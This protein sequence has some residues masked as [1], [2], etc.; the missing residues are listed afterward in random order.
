TTGRDLL[1]SLDMQAQ[2]LL[3]RVLADH[4]GAGVIVDPATGD[5]LAM[6]SSPGFDPNR[7]TP[8]LPVD[9][10][11]RISG[12]ERRPLMN[13]AISATYS[14]G[15]T[16]KPVVA[17]AALASGRAG[18]HT[19]FS[20]PG[21][22]NLGRARFAC[23]YPS[24]HGTVDLRT[25]IEKSCNVYFFQLALQCGL[26]PIREAAA[27]LGLG[28]ATGIELEAEY[29][30]LLPSDA[31]KRRTFNDAWRDGD[32]CNLAIGQGFLAVTPLQMALLTAALAN[33]GTLHAPRLVLGSRAPGEESFE[34]LPPSAAVPVN[35][36]PSAIR[37]VRGAMRDVVMS[38]GG[39][40]RLAQIPNV[41][42]AG[43]TGTAEYGKKGEGLKLGWMIAFAPYDAPRYAV[44]L[45]L[46]EA[47]TGGRTTAPV[48]KEILRGLFEQV[49]P[50][51]G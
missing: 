31:W 43:K 6:T 32:T 33:G 51:R 17:L 50:A 4:V 34:R 10:W 41:V 18:V 11:R 1:L 30:G 5:V 15:S 23:W 48:M 27:A 13:R 14:P 3:D 36:P 47:D 49:P 25:A 19:S 8:V 46:E 26:D 21:Y 24:G 22:Y 12:D 37:F 39:T 42:A 35:L 44:A 20:C 2:Q 9:E 29:A 45:V 28:R 16:F 7:F 40:G 38:P